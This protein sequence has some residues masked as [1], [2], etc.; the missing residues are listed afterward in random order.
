MPST[1]SNNGFELIATGEQ[2]NTW[3]DT[4]NENL[5]LIDEAIDGSVSKALTTT[6]AT[7]TISDG[8][9]T[10]GRHKAVKFTGSPGGECTVTISPNTVQKVYLL[11]NQSDESVVITQGSGGNVSIP[12]GDTAVVSCDGAGAGAA[13]NVYAR[14]R[15]TISGDLTVTSAGVASIA[16]DVVTNAKL[17][18][19]ATSTIKG[20]VTAATGDPE[21][22]TAAQVRTLLNV[23][24]GANAYSHPNHS[25]EVTSTGDGAQVVTV[26]AITNKT[27]LT[28]GLAAT[29]EFLVNDGGVIKRMDASVLA[30]LYLRTDNTGDKPVAGNPYLTQQTLTDG[31]TITW[32]Y[33]SGA[34]AFVTLAGNRT[35]DLASAPE[36]GMWLTI[37]VKQDGTGSR[38][39]SYSSSVFKFGDAGT[40]VLSTDAGKTDILTFRCRGSNAFFVGIASGFAF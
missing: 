6:T 3:G 8:T 4:T 30:E 5:E 2:S 7:L 19:V 36:N 38:T 1:F 22:L 37:V 14:N 20:R 26:S 33:T 32:D 27:E 11:N 31:A 40:P 21:D 35:L 25:G 9:T 24:D 15:L 16:T 34:E 29:D 39:L 23:A 18:N 28:T 17:A 12:A 10:D 13:V